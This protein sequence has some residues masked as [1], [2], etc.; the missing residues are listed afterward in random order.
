MQA[1]ENPQL[2]EAAREVRQRVSRV[3][4]SLETEAAPA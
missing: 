1:I 4:Q 3:I 2:V